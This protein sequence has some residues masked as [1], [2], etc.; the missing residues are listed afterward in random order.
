MFSARFETGSKILCLGA[1]AGQ[2]VTRQDPVDHSKGPQQNVH[3]Q[4]MTQV[5]TRFKVSTATS[6]AQCSVK[7]YLY[8]ILDIACVNVREIQVDNACFSV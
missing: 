3:K 5:D 8:K 6:E 7:I 2:W 4:T 1:D